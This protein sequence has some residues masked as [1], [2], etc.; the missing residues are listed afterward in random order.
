[1]LR[2]LGNVYSTRGEV[3]K[4]MGYLES[5][6]EIVQEH[7]GYTLPYFDIKKGVVRA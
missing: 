7:T 3:Q 1:M 2:N 4:A 6:L 5:A